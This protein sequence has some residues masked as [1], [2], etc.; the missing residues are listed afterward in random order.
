MPNRD[1]RQTP[2][3]NDLALGSSPL[4]LLTP[5]QRDVC[6]LMIEGRLS[7]EIAERLGMSINTVKTHR[8]AVFRKLNATSLVD[9]VRKAR[10][11]EQSPAM[12]PIT[13]PFGQELQSDNGWR[14]LQVLVIEDHAV[15]RSTLIQGLKQMGYGAH[16]AADGD[17]METLLARHSIDIVLLDI[18]L[19][20]G[21]RDGFDLAKRLKQLG[22]YGIIMTTAR[23]D[24]AARV[25]GYQKGAD[26]Y[27]IK[28]VDYFE[29]SAVMQNL[30]RR[31]PPK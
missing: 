21:K 19:G 30:A 22:G 1:T 6:L 4:D 28:P 23:G 20:T 25:Q 29:L 18:A 13:V 2:L 12:T 24:L 10:A 31:M 17:E 9:L 14:A 7:K 3:Q 26:A 5:K 15:L 27:L 16:G 11:P 8:M